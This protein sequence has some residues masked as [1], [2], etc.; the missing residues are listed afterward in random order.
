MHVAHIGVAVTIVGIT[1]VTGYQAERDLR[2]ALGDEVQVGGYTFTFR[3]VT[4]IRGP[5][6]LA[7]RADVAVS[8]G[9][10]LLRTLHPEKRVYSASGNVMTESAI[11]MGLLRH[12]YVSLGE[13]L[14]GS[15]W[16]LH[17]QHKP[18]VG[19]IWAGAV[20]MA[21]G[22]CL[23]AFDRRYVRSKADRRHAAGRSSA[24]PATRSGARP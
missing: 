20:L 2:M 17:I 12:L 6:Y 21:V 22:G 14:D 5:N 7:A 11:D 18:F 13:P 8:S 15:S 16:R 24:T 23:S 10:H 4:D 1:V 3:G 19:W 9:G